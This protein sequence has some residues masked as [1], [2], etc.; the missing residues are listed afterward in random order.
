MTW[1]FEAQACRFV[2]L[3]APLDSVLRHRAIILPTLG[4]QV[5]LQGTGLVPEALRHPARG[6]PTR[7]HGHEQAA[8][9]PEGCR[10]R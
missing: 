10:R 5:R 2:G 7:R 3:Y 9:D 8:V 1:D 4:V 6:L